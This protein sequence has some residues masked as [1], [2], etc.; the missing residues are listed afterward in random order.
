MPGP[1]PTPFDPTAFAKGESEAVSALYRTH[2][3]TVLGWVIRLGGPF[4]VPEEIAQDVFEVVLSRVASFR[5]E[6]KI[7]PWLFGITRRVVANARRRSRFRRFF[8]LDEAKQPSSDAGPEDTY[9]RRRRIQ[10]L[11]ESLPDVQR[12]A[13][14]LV[15]LEGRSANEVAE[16]LDVP[17]GTVYSR[18]HGARKNLASKHG[19]ALIMLREQP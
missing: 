4:L 18:L 3:G 1:E 8:G 5:P 15:E 9:L 14:V 10:T 2:A 17:V 16:L 6:G 11:L 13:I 7:E 12:E 19:P